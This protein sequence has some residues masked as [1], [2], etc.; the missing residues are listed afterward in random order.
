MHV[1]LGEHVRGVGAL[2]TKGATD[3][4]LAAYVTGFPHDA[5]GLSLARTFES[6]WQHIPCQHQR[7]LQENVRIAKY[8]IATWDAKSATSKRERRPLYIQCAV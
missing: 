5:N 3:W 1:R 4:Q 8:L 6:Q 2:Q 7:I